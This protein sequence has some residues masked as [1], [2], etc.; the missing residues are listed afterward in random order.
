[1]SGN[2][3]NMDIDLPTLT[4]SNSSMTLKRSSSAPMINILEGNPSPFHSRSVPMS[5]VESPLSS[6]SEFML[7]YPRSRRFSASFSSTTSKVPA[8]IK[9]IKQEDGIS[10]INREFAQEREMHVNYCLSRSCEDLTL[11][12]P[13]DTVMEDHHA[14]TTIKKS[15]PVTDPLHINPYSFFPNTCSSPS[16]TR[17]GKKGLRSG[18]KFLNTIFQQC[19]S[20]SMQAHVRNTSLSPSPSPS[21][22]RKT[23]NPRRCSSPVSSHLRQ[24]QLHVKRKFDMDTDSVNS[25]PKRIAATVDRVLVVPHPLTHSLS[26]S[27]LESSVNS[28]EQRVPQGT[29]ADLTMGDNCSTSS[30]ESNSPVSAFKMVEQQTDCPRGSAN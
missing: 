9:Q 4:S 17:T 26:S 14:N 2:N 20:P 8:R 1:M 27:S 24:S 16:P 29:V 23:Y 15:K 10:L 21:P 30:N 13:S 7:N 28:P 6:H 12:E 5:G 22:T 19:F 18:R 25:P 11:D 3:M